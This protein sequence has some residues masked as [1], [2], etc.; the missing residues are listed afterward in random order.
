[1]KRFILTMAFAATVGTIGAQTSIDDV[2]RT[3]EANN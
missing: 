1:M 3:V 2:L